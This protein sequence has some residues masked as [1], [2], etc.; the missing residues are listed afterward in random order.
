[1]A[2]R[3]VDRGMSEALRFRANDRR[4][5]QGQP[6]SQG[7]P[8]QGRNESEKHNGAHAVGRADFSCLRAK[9]TKATRTRFGSRCVQ[10]C[11]VTNLSRQI[12]R[13][14]YGAPAPTSGSPP[15][16]L[17]LHRS[18]PSTERTPG[19]FSAHCVRIEEPD[20]EWCPTYGAKHVW[21][22]LLSEHPA[23]ESRL[24]H[25]QRTRTG[26]IRKEWLP[27]GGSGNEIAA[28]ESNRLALTTG[29]SSIKTTASRRNSRT[30]SPGCACTYHPHP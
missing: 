7:K 17:S 24:F 23:S 10:T 15:L 2:W 6:I 30:C 13:H 25:A 3:V 26:G 9:I 22:Y 21:L 4:G 1:M 16:I 28:D 29:E 19:R 11:S 14:I 27:A 18:Y 12:A 20:R 8:V 5:W